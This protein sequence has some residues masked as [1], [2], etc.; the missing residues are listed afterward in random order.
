MNK[1]W[2]VYRPQPKRQLGE[3]ISSRQS[4]VEMAN[5]AVQPVPNRPTLFLAALRRNWLRVRAAGTRKR[6]SEVTNS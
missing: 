3:D 1:Y 4:D 2:M 5:E 6:L